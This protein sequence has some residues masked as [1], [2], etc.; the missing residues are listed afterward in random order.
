MKLIKLAITG[1]S[2]EHPQGGSPSESLRN[3]QKREKF[4]FKRSQ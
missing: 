2:N 4:D 3:L 1:V